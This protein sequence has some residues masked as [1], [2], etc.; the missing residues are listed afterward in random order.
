MKSISRWSA[1][2]VGFGK[3]GA[4]P[5]KAPRLKLSRRKAGAKRG[6]IKGAPNPVARLYE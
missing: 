4:R 3:T 6:G 2:K 1:S 5:R